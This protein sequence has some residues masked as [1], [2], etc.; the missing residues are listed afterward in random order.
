MNYYCGYQG[1]L[2]TRINFPKNFLLNFYVHNLPFFLG[3]R[4]I[5]AS[6]GLASKKPTDITPKLSSVYCVGLHTYDDKT[7]RRCGAYHRGPAGTTLVYLLPVKSHQLW[8]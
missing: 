5:T 6:S 3:P 7:N 1:T 8:D 2:K 4:Q